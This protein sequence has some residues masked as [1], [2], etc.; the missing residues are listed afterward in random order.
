MTLPRFVRRF[1]QRVFW[2]VFLVVSLYFIE[3]RADFFFGPAIYEAGDDAANALQIARARHGVEL[4]GNY[5]RWGFHHPGPAFFYVYAGG[6]LILRKLLRLVAAPGIAHV[7]TGVVLH[8]FFFAASLAIIAFYARSRRLI[9]LLLAAA[10]AHFRLVDRAFVSIWPPNQLLM[11]FLLLIVAGSSVAT[12][13][14]RHLPLFVLASGFLVHGHVNQPLFVGATWITAALLFWRNRGSLPAYPLFRKREIWV[15]AAFACAFAVPLLFDA[16]RGA[17]SN[18]AAIL[19]HVREHTGEWKTFNDSVFYFAHFVTYWTSQEMPS[20]SWRTL[21]A[22]HPGVMALWLLALVIFLA[23]AV[24]RGLTA[25]PQ[26]QSRRARDFLQ[27]FVFITATALGASIA[28][29]MKMDG[30]MFAF[31]STFNYAILF[32]VLVPSVVLLHRLLP[33]RARWPEW[34]AIIALAFVAFAGRGIPVPMEQLSK[35][36]ALP[37]SAV[38]RLTSGDSAGKRPLLWHSPTVWVQTASL[39]LAMERRKIDFGVRRNFT[40]LMG[41]Q[42]LG[43]PGDSLRHP[44]EQST[45]LLATKP[46]LAVFVDDMIDLGKDCYAQQWQRLRRMAP[47][48]EISFNDRIA[49]IEGFSE[50]EERFRWSDARHAAVFLPLAA[51][52]RDAQLRLLL[53]GMSHPR[54]NLTQHIA[55]RVG[56]R[57]VAQWQIADEAPFGLTLPADLVATEVRERGGVI[58]D[59]DLPDATTPRSLGINQDTRLLGIAVH[60]ITCIE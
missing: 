37:K 26:M 12:G 14:L 50:A 27:A 4:L 58:L 17:A 24:S 45:W 39:G 48:T 29:G 52:G 43:S 28:W 57:V 19:T 30:P 33:Q 46:E 49:F 22:A 60:S 10:L 42:H 25:G 32:C 20:G 8:S 7:L 1:D 13:R 18:I 3:L 47:G 11:P 36:S 59:F 34:L 21:F 6:E 38:S 31:N 44:A 54:S 5:S 2:S 56:E 9:V 15:S 35:S 53:H 40:L 23:S 55:V 51:T 41:S 16:S